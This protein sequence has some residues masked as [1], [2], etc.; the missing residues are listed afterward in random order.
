MN[1]TVQLATVIPATMQHKLDEVR[2]L[3]QTPH[4]LF[5]DL[6]ALGYICMGL[7]TLFGSFV[8]T[9]NEHVNVLKVHS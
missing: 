2:V 3:E 9:L 7:A 1:Y 4:S 5:W 6:D 8:Q